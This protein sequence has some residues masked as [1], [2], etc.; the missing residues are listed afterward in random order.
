[1]KI[2]WRRK[3]RHLKERKRKPS[4]KCRSSKNRFV[5]SLILTDIKNHFYRSLHVNLYLTFFFFLKTEQLKEKQKQS[6]EKVSCTAK[7]MQELEVRTGQSEDSSEVV[8]CVSTHPSKLTRSSLL[9]FY[10]RNFWYRKHAMIP[11]LKRRTNTHSCLKKWRKPLC[12]T[13][14]RSVAVG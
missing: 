14:L 4:R 2:R 11:W 13:K 5:T 12:K 8:S 10:R 3:F 6:K 7:R 1:M 9:T